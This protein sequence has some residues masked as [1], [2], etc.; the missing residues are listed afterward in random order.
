MVGQYVT[1][2]LFP[3]DHPYHLLTI[4]TP[5]GSRRARPCSTTLCS[6]LPRVVRAEQ[7]DPGHRRRRRQEQ[8]ARPRRP[9]K[10]FGPIPG[11][12]V[13]DR[14]RWKDPQPVALDRREA[15]STST[16][17][18]SCLVSTCRGPHRGSSPPE[19]CR[20]RSRRPASCRAGRRV[21]STS[22]SCTISRSRSDVSA[23]QG[24]SQL[25]S[26]F[27][28]VATAQP[29]HTADELR[30]A[31]DFELRHAGGRGHQ[32]R[33]AR[34]RQDGLRCP[35]RSSSSRRSARGRTRSTSTTR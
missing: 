1:A 5:G 14:S 2:A 13:A 11:G 9:G 22:T 7:R 28:I 30:T 25:G 6:V 15:S 18:W 23:N 12:A 4:G 31:I 29:A 35:A 3:V 21:G 26:Q 33:R 16:P 24:S 32:G 17:A 27:T 34:P 19:T 20:A 10:Y 8:G